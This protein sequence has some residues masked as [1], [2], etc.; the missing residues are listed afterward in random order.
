MFCSVCHLYDLN[1]HRN[2]FVHGC[3]TTKVESVR[4]DELS[5]QHKAAEGAYCAHRH[6]E[7]ASMEVS[8]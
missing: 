7:R 8:V 2:Q 1:E 3:L 5:Q 6:L 4:E